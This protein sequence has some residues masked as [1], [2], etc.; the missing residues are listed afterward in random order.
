V[1]TLARIEQSAKNY[2]VMLFHNPKD[3]AERDT[4]VS[5]VERRPDMWDP[6]M[7]EVA[8]KQIAEMPEFYWR[9]LGLRISTPAQRR[10]RM[11]HYVR[12]HAH[13]HERG[14]GRSRSTQAT[15]FS[16]IGRW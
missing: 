13:H 4:F 12:L 11:H 10:Q 6:T 1:T 2:L 9:E 14:P 15:C 8:K 3:L 5:F 7:S 16:G